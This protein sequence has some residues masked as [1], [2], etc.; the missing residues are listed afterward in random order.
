MVPGPTPVYRGASCRQNTEKCGKGLILLSELLP[1]SLQTELQLRSLRRCDQSLTVR[2]T[3][4]ALGKKTSPTQS[5]LI[6]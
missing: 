6:P 5:L 1:F 3:H 4:R 2:V